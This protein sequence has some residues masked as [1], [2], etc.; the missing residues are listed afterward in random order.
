MY[1]MMFW[2]Y[3]LI[4][5]CHLTFLILVAIHILLLNIEIEPIKNLINE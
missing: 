4:L 2:F 1:T 3:L 5:T